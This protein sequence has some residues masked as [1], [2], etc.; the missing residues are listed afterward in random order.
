MLCAY[1]TTME[2]TDGL[3]VG[4][5]SLSKCESNGFKRDPDEGVPEVSEAERTYLKRFFDEP[6]DDFNTALL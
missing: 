6:V 3:H 1:L 2:K 5:C 4:K